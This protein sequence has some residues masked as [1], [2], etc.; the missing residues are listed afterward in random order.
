MESDDEILEQLAEALQ[1]RSLAVDAS[2]EPDR[3]RAEAL[4]RTVVT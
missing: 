3:A 1:G 2:D 4:V